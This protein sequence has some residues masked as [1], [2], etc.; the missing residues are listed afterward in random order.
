MSILSSASIPAVSDLPG[1][2]TYVPQVFAINGR[3][4]RCR[5]LAYSLATSMVFTLAALIIG[6]TIAVVAPSLV[7]LSIAFYIPAV[8]Y[9]FI[10]TI[11]RLNDMNKSGWLSLLLL[12]PIVN[13]LFMLW[14][15]FWPGS[16]GSNHH[17]PRPSANSGW[18]IA[19]AS[20]MAIAFVGG[21]L[22]AVSLPAYQQYLEKAGAAQL[23]ETLLAPG[24]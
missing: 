13:L 23:E 5:Y 21:L 2:A 14:L 8:A 12:L 24:R 17:G 20:L 10:L 9:S 22:A 7:F 18:V 1:T 15:V 16:A 3:L 4:G 19:G 11:R 6:A